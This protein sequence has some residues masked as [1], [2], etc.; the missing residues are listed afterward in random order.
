M[1]AVC[2]LLVSVDAIINPLYFIYQKLS[3]YPFL[4]LRDERVLSF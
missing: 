1:S 2:Y 4:L 3:L